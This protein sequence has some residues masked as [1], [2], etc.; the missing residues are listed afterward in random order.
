[1]RRSVLLAAAVAITFSLP[2]V[3]VAEALATVSDLDLLQ[4]TREAVG[5]QD[6][7]LALKLLTEMQRRGTGIFAGAKR[8]VCEEVIVLPDGITDWKFHAVARQ[9]YIRSAMSRR[10]EEGSCGCLFADFSFD[11]FVQQSLGRPA[12][13]LMNAD[14]EAL[15]K[16]RDQ[17][18]RETEAR[19]RD[20]EQS[21]RAE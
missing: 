17:D 9:A 11:A 12:A 16:V 19:Y 14:Q 6:A 3:A 5:A 18:R 20:L 15:A 2:R 1:M 21:C 4:Q 10:L 8:A 13:D 7:D